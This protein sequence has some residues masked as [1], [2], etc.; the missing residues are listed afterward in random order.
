[1]CQLTV[2]LLLAGCEIERQQP[3][4]PGSPS[5]EGAVMAAEIEALSVLIQ[6]RALAIQAAGDPEALAG[7]EPPDLD[8]IRAEL[9][10][11]RVQRDQLAATLE[12]MEQLA[13]SPVE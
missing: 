9:E 11:L 13:A 3:A 10:Q 8:A 12:A 6:E 7:G 2:L 5:A 1:M 4:S